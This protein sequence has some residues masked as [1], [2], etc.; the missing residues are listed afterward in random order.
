MTVVLHL[1]G[2]H[3]SIR[4]AA[5]GLEVLRDACLLLLQWWGEK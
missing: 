4:T 1:V 5:C 2:V 3:A